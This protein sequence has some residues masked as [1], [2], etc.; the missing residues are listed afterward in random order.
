MTRD[1]VR[2]IALVTSDPAVLQACDRALAGDVDAWQ[3]CE[4]IAARRAVV[5]TVTRGD[6]PPVQQRVTSLAS[7]VE[8]FDPFQPRRLRVVRCR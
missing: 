1:D 3:Q 7:A 8:K 6:E 2:L 4:Q 5:V